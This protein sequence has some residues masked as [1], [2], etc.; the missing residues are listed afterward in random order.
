MMIRLVWTNSVDITMDAIE[1]MLQE[2][3]GVPR[4]LTSDNPKCFAIKADKHDPTLNP[5]FERLASHYDFRIECLPPQD[6]KKKGKVER[7]MPYARR[8]F[9]AFNTDNFQLE[10][11][12][13]YINKKCV[14][15]NERR[16][17]T[18]DLKQGLLPSV[19]KISDVFRK[20]IVYF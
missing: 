12:Q 6:P 18:T 13:E 2:L 19:W 8:I 9:E 10:K 17:G 4:K 3:G 15:A 5:S 1:G 11:A 14:I 7:M 16:H 20:K